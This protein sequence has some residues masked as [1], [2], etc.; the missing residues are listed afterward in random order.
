LGD[1]RVAA[2]AL[3]CV[4][5][6]SRRRR[7]T[8][9]SHAVYRQITSSPVRGR[10]QRLSSPSSVSP[11]ADAAAAGRVRSSSV[12]SERAF[13]FQGLGVEASFRAVGAAEGRNSSGFLAG[14]VQPNSVLRPEPFF[15][16]LKFSDRRFPGPVRPNQT[17]P[18]PWPVPCAVTLH[19]SHR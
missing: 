3:P 9:P 11:T 17:R 12:T 16:G 13:L 8:E 6:E 7:E 10:R 18:K 2:I 5:V 19:R 15:Y 14:S 4:A 1:G